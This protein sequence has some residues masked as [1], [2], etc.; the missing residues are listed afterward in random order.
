MATSHPIRRRRK[1]SRE[2]LTLFPDTPRWCQR[3][4][5][6]LP[7]SAFNHDL[8][9]KDGLNSHCRECRSAANKAS[10]STQA[11]EFAIRHL[12]RTYGLEPEAF[13]ARVQAQGNACAICGN[14]MGQGKGRHVDH[15]HKTGRVRAIL[16]HHCNCALGHAK[17]DPSLLRA[18]A[19]Y[20]EAHNVQ[21]P[22]TE[23]TGRNPKL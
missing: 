23:I 18:M 1:A 12:R 13:N 9:N 14:D 6:L 5:R 19:D 16:C 22:E 4:E 3:C 7:P 20:I 2:P 10:Y 21:C 17:D 11:A 8:K 15:C